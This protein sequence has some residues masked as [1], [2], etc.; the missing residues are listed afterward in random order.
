MAPSLGPAATL[1]ARV[2]I[3]TGVDATDVHPVLWTFLGAIALRHRTETGHELVVTS[4]RRPPGPRASKHSPGLGGLCEAA[5]LRRWQLDTTHSAAAFANVLQHLY[6]ACIG[7]VLEPEWLS[8]SEIA[9]R[10][11]L[12]KIT[13]HIHIELKRT[14]WPF[15]L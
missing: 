7:V 5:D 4:L 11:G 10:G 15:Q 12:D 6:G 1:A 2:N 3:K 9:A 14:D 13:G 8:E